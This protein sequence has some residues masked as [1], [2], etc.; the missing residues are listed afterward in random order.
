YNERENLAA[1]VREVRQAL[2]AA[3][4]LIT[5][6]N[7]PDGTGRLADEL[8]AADPHVHVIHRAG[9]L[10]LG[11]AILGAMRWAMEHGYD[12]FVNMDA[13]FSHH[14]R[15]LPA[16]LEGMKKND[17]MIGS[18]YVPGGGSANWPLS[19]RLM[20][21][22]VNTVVRLLMRIPAQDTSGGYRCYRVAKLRQA[23][24]ENLLSRGYSFQQEVL[25]RCRR[26][27]ARIGETPILFEDRRAGTSKVSPKEA[28]RSMATILR[29]GLRAF[30]GLDRPAGSAPARNGRPAG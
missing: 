3:D 27:G 7:S 30:F 4:V 23:D 22:G 1:L 10:G 20:S 12:L 24:L 26:A 5:D 14:P 11:T 21:R 6:D 18:R 2:P 17:V 28:A 19:R 13:D 16:L 8:A 29:I 25:Y 15:Y 9:K